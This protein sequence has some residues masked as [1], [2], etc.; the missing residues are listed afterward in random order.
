MTNELIKECKAVA[1]K[2]PEGYSLSVEIIADAIQSVPTH[3]VVDS[4]KVKLDTDGKTI[5][6]N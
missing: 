5:K 2:A 1:G 4:W 6:G 3:V